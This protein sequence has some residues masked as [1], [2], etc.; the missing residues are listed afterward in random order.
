MATKGAATVS[1]CLPAR[2]EAATVGPIVAAIV[3]EL[4]ERQP[5]VDEVVVVDDGSAD[6]TARVAG[7][8]GARVVSHPEPLGKGG[9]L[10]TSLAAS[11]GELV[12][13][14][15]ADLVAFDPIFVTGLLEPLLASPVVAF[16]K[17]CYRRDLEGRAGEGGRVTELV[18]RPL[19][20]RFFPHLRGFT[21]PLAGEYAG[22]RH[23][24]EKLDL[25]PGYGVDLG[26]L[27]DVAELVG[28]EAMV[29]VDLGRRRH[30]NRPL[31]DLAPHAEAVLAVALDRAGLGPAPGPEGPR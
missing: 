30:R 7:E 21:Q 13:W 2:D 5:L 27:I 28:V 25:A 24:L 23:V 6:A 1:V 22:R 20:A 29:Q 10:Q 12:V 8:A 3:S 18:A 17:A 31:A 4:V 15:D 16:T 14:C 26:V 9:A 19:V 11:S